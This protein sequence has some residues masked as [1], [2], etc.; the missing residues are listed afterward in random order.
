MHHRQRARPCQTESLTLTSLSAGGYGF[1]L[2][3]QYVKGLF[4]CPR[5]RQSYVHEQWIQASQVRCRAC[6]HPGA[7]T[8]VSVEEQLDEGAG[9]S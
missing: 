9:R 1:R 6:D 2:M 3:T 8:Y 4:L 5:C 7:L